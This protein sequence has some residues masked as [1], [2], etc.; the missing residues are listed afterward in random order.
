MTIEIDLKKNKFRHYKL[1]MINLFY[2]EIYINHMLSNWHLPFVDFPSIIFSKE[3]SEKEDVI[4]V[5]VFLEEKEIK[6]PPIFSKLIQNE[7]VS[8]KLK[9]K[10]IVTLYGINLTE[11][12]QYNI[13]L[14]LPINIFSSSNTEEKVALSSAIDAFQSLSN[15]GKKNVAVYLRNVSKFYWKICICFLLVLILNR[16]L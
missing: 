8:E 3:F 11:K 15:L 10:S 13:C 14:I 6:C 4:V 16:Q 5:P 9:S 2:E 1:N 12:P 7:V